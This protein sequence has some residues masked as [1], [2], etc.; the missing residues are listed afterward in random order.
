MSTFPPDIEAFVQAKLASGQFQSRD[1]LTVEAVRVLREKQ[2]SGL[3]K[4]MH[5][6]GE[7][8]LAQV[9]MD[10]AQNL[11]PDP[12]DELARLVGDHAAVRLVGLAR[13]LAGGVRQAADRLGGNVVEYLSEEN[14]VLLARAPF[15]NWCDDMAQLQHRLAALDASLATLEHRGGR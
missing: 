2:P 1:E 11:R 12:E 9:V 15:E 14:P 3:A 13:G 4:L 8:A 5:I 6:E 7:A 10:L